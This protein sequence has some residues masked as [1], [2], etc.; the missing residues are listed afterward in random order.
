M[1]LFGEI[2]LGFVIVAV[3]FAVYV[4]IDISLNGIDRE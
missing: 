2:F 1:T 4:F 3:M